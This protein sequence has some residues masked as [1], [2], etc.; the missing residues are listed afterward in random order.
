MTLS[1]EAARLLHE[2]GRL[3]EAAAAYRAVPS[4][5]P[6]HYRALNNLGLILEGEGRLPEAADTLDAAVAANGESAIL[7]CNR[8]RILHRLGLLQEAVAGYRRS[9]ELDPGWVDPQHNLA[10]ALEERGDLGDAEVWYRRAINLEPGNI[11][12]HRRLG[13]ILF[14][15]GHVSE[16]LTHYQ[17]ALRIDPNTA[18]AHFDLAKALTALGSYE[19]ALDAYRRCLDIEPRSG[20]AYQNLV[21]L[22][23]RQGRLSEAADVLNAWIGR[24]PEDPVPRHLLAAVTGE[25]VPERTSDDTVRQLFNELAAS[26]DSTLARLDYQAPQLVLAAIVKLYPPEQA[27]CDCDILD[28]GCGTGLC[29]PLLRPRARRLIGVDLSSGMLEKASQRG[30]YDELVE[31]ELTDY[32]RRRQGCL[33]IIVSTDT[34]NYFGALDGVLGAAAGALRDNGHLVFT[35]ECETVMPSSP[36][37]LQPNGR[38]SHGEVYIRATIGDA[39]LSLVSLRRYTLR[40][41][42]MDAVQGWLV[43]CARP[44]TDTDRS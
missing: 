12:A 32:L 15:A 16:A 10:I 1:F 31:G 3:S 18:R 26:F 25:G 17:Q 41:E 36:W 20:P 33:D 23:R 43:S 29:G 14:D 21:D 13:D 34:L 42:G 44:I 22:L 7:H 35:L 28:A 24:A 27:V 30:V 19:E 9:I 38:Y 5:D 37:R 40:R 11:P 2:Q 8:A 39:G 4:E 6:D